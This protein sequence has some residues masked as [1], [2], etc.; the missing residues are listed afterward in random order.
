M[1]SVYYRYCPLLNQAKRPKW[2]NKTICLNSFI[3]SIDNLIE[4][5]TIGVELKIF[6]DA[7]SNLS[8]GEYNLFETLKNK[9]KFVNVEK[10]NLKSN[11]GSYQQV[12]E[13]ACASR[14]SEIVLLTEDDYIWRKG[15][16][17]EMV[18]AFQ[19]IDCDYVTPYDHPVRYDWSYYN[20][21]DFPHWENRIFCTGSWHF[22]SQESTCMTFMVKSDI[23]KE[24]REYHL[25]Y[26][27]INQKA[28]NDRELFRFLQKLGGH[29]YSQHKKRLLLGP[30]PS[31]ATH[32]HLPYLAHT[33]DWNKIASECKNIKY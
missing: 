16:L 15:S 23:L 1:L 13:E 6:I 25:R 31:L 21:V 26:S 20:G 19:T 7:F 10:Y 27:P 18:K 4:A 8:E 3:Q 11:T 12:L 2:F 29:H 9:K 32:A 24:D 5:N 33:I 14:Q 17:I 28:P 22:R 30:V